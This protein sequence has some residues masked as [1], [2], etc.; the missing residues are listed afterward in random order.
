MTYEY[1]WSPSYSVGNRT[2]D[3]QHQKLLQICKRVSD[4]RCDGT[5]DGIGEFHSILNDLA[6][7]ASKHFQTEEDVLRRAGY[8]ALEE[9]KKEHDQYSERLVDFLCDA[10][11]GKVDRESLEDFLGK[12]W[13]NHILVSD[14]QYSAYVTKADAPGNDS[15]WIR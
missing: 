11:D 9:Q 13:V 5:K 2:L 4:S 12:W 6:F 10:I 1:T 15:I 7:Y 8:P 14:M 3:A